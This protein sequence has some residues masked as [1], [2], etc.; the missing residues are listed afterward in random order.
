MMKIKNST[1]YFNQAR[2]AESME[3]DDARFDDAHSVFAEADSTTNEAT[4]DFSTT[5]QRASTLYMCII[6]SICCRTFMG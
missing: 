5:A 2:P 3:A 6:Y 4:M 1:F